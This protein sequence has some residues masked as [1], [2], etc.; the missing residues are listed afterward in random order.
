MSMKNSIDTGIRTRDLPTCSAVP[1]PTAPP[2]ACPSLH[3]LYANVLQVLFLTFNLRKIITTEKYKIRSI[4]AGKMKQNVMLVLLR[5]PLGMS[6]FSA[7][8]RS[9]GNRRQ[10][11]RGAWNKERFVTV[12]NFYKRNIHTK[13]KNRFLVVDPS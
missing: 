1:Q 6:R 7:H 5:R 8:M 12:R 4:I 3:S 13:F 9:L 2:A 10:P 11:K